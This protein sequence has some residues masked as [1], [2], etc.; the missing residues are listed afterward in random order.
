MSGPAKLPRKIKCET[1]LR[2]PFKRIGQRLFESAD[3]RE[4]I[5]NKSLRQLLN[6]NGDNT[7]HRK[8]LPENVVAITKTVTVKD[9]MGREAVW[10][11]TFLMSIADYFKV[12][13]QADLAL[14]EPHFIKPL[15]KPPGML[16]PLTMKV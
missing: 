6:L 1:F 9:E 12:H 15:E 8:L 13:E 4:I 7:I 14:F 10:N 16:K 11:Q 5:S 3:T 2:G